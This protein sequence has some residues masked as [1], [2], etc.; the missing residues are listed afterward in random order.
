MIYSMI[1]IEY[2][3]EKDKVTFLYVC[4]KHETNE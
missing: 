3:L 2:S 4:K 1:V